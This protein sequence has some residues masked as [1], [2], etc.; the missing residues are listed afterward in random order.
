V[1]G[2]VIIVWPPQ[3]RAK[4]NMLAGKSDKKIFMAHLRSLCAALIVAQLN[5]RSMLKLPRPFVIEVGSAT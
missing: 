4:I 2:D 1:Q 5:A 3:P